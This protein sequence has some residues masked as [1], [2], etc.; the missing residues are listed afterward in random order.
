MKNK[1]LL[2]VIYN[3]INLLKV[4]LYGLLILGIYYSTFIWLIGHD[5]ARDDFTYCY[6]IPFVIAY[7]IWEKRERLGLIP[8]IFGL[9]LFWPGELGG[10]F[11]TL[12]LSCWLV[13]V[14]LLWMHLG[15]QKIKTMAFAL[16]LSLS[17]FPL[18]IFLYNKVSVWLKL[19]SSQMGVAMLQFYGMTAYRE[20]NVIDLGFMKLQ[21]VDACNG[22]R[23][24]IPLIIIGLILAYFFKAALWKRAVVVFSTIP[25]AILVNGIRI[26]LT[27][28]LCQ[29]WDPNIAKN[30]FHDFSG[31]FIFMLSL[32]ILLLEIKILRK[33]GPSKKKPLSSHGPSSS[34]GHV[35]SFPSVIK[36]QTSLHN[37]AKSFR[38]LRKKKNLITIVSVVLLTATLAFS[39]GVNFREKIPMMKSFSKFPDQVQE[40]SGVRQSMDQK[41]IESL[42]LS[43]YIIVDYNHK[44]KGSVNFYMAYYESQRKGESIHSPATCLPG[45]GWIF[46]ESGTIKIDTPNYSGGSM[47]VNRA[48]MQKLGYRQLSYYWFSQRGRILTNAYQLKIFTFWDALTKQRTDGALVRLIT[49]V[50]NFEEVGDADKRLQGFMQKILP[51][52]EEYIPGKEI[53]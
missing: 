29:V 21:V 47:R 24:L 49:P 52:L 43:D 26:G 30:F 20:G 25:L 15:R 51:L 6:L 12:Y 45:S 1:N 44:D 19:I 53:S 16:I 31:W 7:L 11:F 8:F 18:P 39:K 3:P 34:P 46:N 41:I 9:M 17:M 50:Y 33:I 23:Y 35:G 22:L 48:F 5:W 14:G 2:E 10:E 13:E 27:G 42:D 28:I 36:N 38:S 40:W 32:G 4:G 37:E